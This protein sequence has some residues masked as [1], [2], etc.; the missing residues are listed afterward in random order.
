VVAERSADGREQ[1]TD[2]LVNVN[3][4]TSFDREWRGNATATE[5]NQARTQ[6]RQQTSM[7]G[8]GGS[9]MG[10]LGGPSICGGPAFFGGGYGQPRME[11]RPEQSSS[12]REAAR[13]GARVYEQQRDQMI[14]DARRERGQQTHS[15]AAHQS[16]GSRHA[17]S[18]RGSRGSAGDMAYASRLAQEE[19]RRAGM[20]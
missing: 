15:S 17:G 18:G 3:D 9:P 10:L 12:D 6:A 4:G 11:Y 8:G 7:L 20:Y 1:R 14:A 5:I 2:N 13:Q 16:S 19:A